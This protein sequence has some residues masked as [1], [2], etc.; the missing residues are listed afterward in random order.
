MLFFTFLK[1]NRYFNY[2]LLA[3]YQLAPGFFLDYCILAQQSIHATPFAT[4]ASASLSKMYGTKG[5]PGLCI[6]I[7]SF[8][9]AFNVP[10]TMRRSRAMHKET[11]LTICVY[12]PFLGCKFLMVTL[13][14][15][16]CV[17]FRPS[18]LMSSPKMTNKHVLRAR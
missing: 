1:N 17:L 13:C 18:I 9:S 3:A 8:Y 15:H 16:L 5:S 7:I 14:A 12:I 4:I 2:V 6:N 10:S 11:S